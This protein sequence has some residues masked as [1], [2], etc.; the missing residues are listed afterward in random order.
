M[1]LGARGDFALARGTNVSDNN[2]PTLVCRNAGCNYQNWVN[3]TLSISLGRDWGCE[4]L[5]NG[6]VQ[7]WG[8]NYPSGDSVPSGGNPESTLNFPKQVHLAR[9]TTVVETGSRHACA[10]LDNGSIQC[11]GN[12]EF[13]QLGLGYSCNSNGISGNCSN[14]APNNYIHYPEYVLLPQGKTALALNVYDHNSCAI[15]NDNSYMCWGQF[16]ATNG[17]PTYL[18]DTISERILMADGQI[19]VDSRNKLRM[20]DPNEGLFLLNYQEFDVY[21]PDWENNAN[22]EWDII[23]Q[24]FRTISRSYSSSTGL[25]ACVILLNNSVPCSAQKGYTNYGYSGELSRAWIE[26]P[27][28]QNP[29]AIVSKVEGYDFGISCIALNN[30]S[31]QCWGVN[32][33]GEI[34]DG[35]YC[36]DGAVNCIDGIGY[37]DSLRYVAMPSGRHL[38]LGE[39]DHDG[40]GVVTILD[41]CP[42]STIVWSSDNNSDIDSDGCRDQD[43]DSDDDN[44]GYTD[45][46]DAYPLDSR[47]YQSLTMDDGWVVGGNYERVAIDQYSGYVSPSNYFFTESGLSRDAYPGL[48][49]SGTEDY[50]SL[51]GPASGSMSVIDSDGNIRL[52]SAPYNEGVTISNYTLNI[53]YPIGA[54]SHGCF[55]LLEGGLTCQGPENTGYDMFNVSFPGSIFIRQ[56]SGVDSTFYGRGSLCVVTEIGEVFCSVSLNSLDQWEKFDS[57]TDENS[58][59]LLGGYSGSTEV[60]SIHLAPDDGGQTRKCIVFIDGNASCSGNNA[61]GQIGN[62]YVSNNDFGFDYPVYFPSGISPSIVTMA[63]AKF[64][65]C[66]LFINGSVYCWGSTM[67]VS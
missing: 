59:F 5:V 30:G 40:D 45:D 44:D 26:L 14:T 24:G 58:L 48:A 66:A 3:Q 17:T 53:S 25:E 37:V 16:S 57:F 49:T 18:N 19:A 15:L 13:G 27:S 33:G 46:T 55:I 64:S 23:D 1:V 54:G 22:W 9:P 47:F 50:L 20:L 62:G 51:S 8:V 34:G 60:K 52:I 10:I 65:S 28:G 29:S 56:I 32:S 39:M 11:W 31:V 7:C 36:Y 4:L 6:S 12:N 43:E 42:Y 67:L 41:S 61:Y 2:I 35:T 38:S 63:V 21:P